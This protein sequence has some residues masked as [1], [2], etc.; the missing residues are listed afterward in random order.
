MA[1]SPAATGQPQASAAPQIADIHRA[2]ET[3]LARAIAMAKEARAAGAIN[4]F[5]H[6]LVGLGLKQEGR[7]D[8]AVAEFGR[9]LELEPNN[10]RLTEEVGFCL[11][12]AGRRFEAARVFGAA[13]R[14]DPNSPD[15]SFG[16]GWAAE[17]V[18]ELD[19]AEAG[20]K[21][22][23]ELDPRHADAMAGL[24]GLAVRRRE[25]DRANDFAER[26]IAIDPN[27]T[28][29]MTIL[30]RVEIGQGHV[31]AAEVRLNEIIGLERL[32][33]QAR[34]NARFLLGDA[35]DGDGRYQQAFTAYSQGKAELKEAYADEFEGPNKNT[36]YDG[37]EEVL[38][39]FLDTPADAWSKPVRDT[40]D[41]PARRHAFLVGFPRSGTTLLEQ[42][43]AAHPDIVA[44]DER[45]VMLD[46]EMEFLTRP[47][48][49]KRLGGVV[50]ELLEPYQQAYWRRVR[51]F[52]V[53]PGGKVFVDKH[54]LSTFRLPLIF[55]VFPYARIIF[56]LRDPRDVVLSCFRRSFNMNAAMYE[57]NSIERAARYYDAVMR[58]GEVYFERLPL[59]VCRVRYEDLVS[60]FETTAKRVSEFL[61][62]EWNAQMKDFAKSAAEGRRIATPSSTQVLRGLYAEG[63]GQWR[64]YA[65]AME[66]AME[67][68]RPWVEKFGYE[69]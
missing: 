48:G 30:A 1:K 5:I 21:R 61:G 49:V 16:F 52:G 63:V 59:E 60:D 2:A 11:L 41:S 8:E 6:Y 58:A 65:F 40:S 55:K 18:G 15:A 62:V 64:N 23:L 31:E 4:A 69:P 36:A 33:P 44:L 14:L 39:E 24:A 19:A 34:T 51:A 28:D 67:I 12:Q 29:A 56:A 42:V 68:L 7:L 37:V 50:S 45:P 54:P 9:G 43:L 20:F 38:S 53:E 46:A 32:H 47:G 22:T 26:A 13:V 10:P 66:P 25:W 27:Q 17:R 57:F 35:L 3:D